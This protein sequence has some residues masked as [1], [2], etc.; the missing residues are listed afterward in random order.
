MKPNEDR[1]VIAEAFMCPYCSSNLGVD[2]IEQACAEPFNGTIIEC[3][4]CEKEINVDILF[5]IRG[6]E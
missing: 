3:P 1:I 4:S 5:K 6:E 2:N